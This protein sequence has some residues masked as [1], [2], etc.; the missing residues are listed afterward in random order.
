MN[1]KK[2]SVK[3]KS[4]QISLISLILHEHKIQVEI[5]FKTKVSVSL[6]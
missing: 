4:K 6:L 3:F 1:L 2:N 5:K